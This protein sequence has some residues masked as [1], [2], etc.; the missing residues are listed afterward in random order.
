MGTEVEGEVIIRDIREL[1]KVVQ[2]NLV[3]DRSRI[4]SLRL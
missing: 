2:G 1:P 4:S 3:L